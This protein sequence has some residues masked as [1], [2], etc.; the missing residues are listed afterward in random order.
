MEAKYPK[1]CPRACSSFCPSPV[2]APLEQANC[3]G[4]STRHYHT[5][6]T[7]SH[8]FCFTAFNLLPL[9]LTSVTQPPQWRYCQASTQTVI[10]RNLD[11]RDRIGEGWRIC[12]CSI[13]IRWQS[14]CTK[15][16]C[17]RVGVKIE[18]LVDDMHYAVEN[19]EVGISC[20]CG[21]D[22]E[23]VIAVVA[24]VYGRPFDRGVIFCAD[25]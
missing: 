1:T 19:K 21:F 18:D 24:E 5:H 10:S 11:A 13:R 16:C 20:R 12:S 7:P 4:N 6:H 9:F 23:I 8:L 25:I 17:G 2:D 15:R 3:K 14:N 22:E